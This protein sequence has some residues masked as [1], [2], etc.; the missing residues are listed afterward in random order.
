MS[1]TMKRMRAYLQRLG[2]THTKVF[3]AILAKREVADLAGV[4]DDDLFGFAEELRSGAG[5]VTGFVLARQR[6]IS[7]EADAFDDD[8]QPVSTAQ[9]INALAVELYKNADGEPSLI[10]VVPPDTSARDAIAMMATAHYSL[11]RKGL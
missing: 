11:A 7:L 9:A 10:D 5:L 6:G 2:D 4:D 3:A 8:D 1:D